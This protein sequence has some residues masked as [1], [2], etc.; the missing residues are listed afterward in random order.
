MENCEPVI[1]V[2]DQIYAAGC[3]HPLV[4]AC[5][6]LHKRNMFPDASFFNLFFSPQDFNEKN[7]LRFSSQ[8]RGTITPCTEFSVNIQSM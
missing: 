7:C 5:F 4:A 2:G 1:A 8:K 3:L 6:H